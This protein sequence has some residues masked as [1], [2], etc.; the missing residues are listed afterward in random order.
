MGINT[1]RLFSLLLSFFFF[2]FNSLNWLVF[3]GAVMKHPDKSDLMEKGLLLAHGLG[4]LH[5]GGV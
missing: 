4:T 3:P 5:H 1:S 2:F